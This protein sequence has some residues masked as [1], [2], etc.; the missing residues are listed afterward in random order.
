VPSASEYSLPID[1][2]DVEAM[3]LAKKAVRLI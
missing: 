1:S 3:P 2:L